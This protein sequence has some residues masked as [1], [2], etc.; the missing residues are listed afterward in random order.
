[1]SKTFLE[2]KQHPYSDIEGYQILLEDT[3]MAAWNWSL[4]VICIAVN[5]KNPF[6]PDMSDVL[7][8]MSDVL[9]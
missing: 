5:M 9:A 8:L 4:D 6:L 3:I 7:L 2:Y 1:M